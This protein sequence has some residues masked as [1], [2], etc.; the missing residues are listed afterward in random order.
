MIGVIR[1]FWGEYC[2]LQSSF[3]LRTLVFA[4]KILTEEAADDWLRNFNECNMKL[5]C[6]N[7]EVEE[8]INRLEREMNYLGVSCL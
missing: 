6:N 2:S 8:S 3:G 1:S 5:Q 4:G 7:Q